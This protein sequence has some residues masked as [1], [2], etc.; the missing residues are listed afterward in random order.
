MG[1]LLYGIIVVHGVLIYPARIC[2]VDNKQ[3]D[4]PDGEADYKENGH[5]TFARDVKLPHLSPGTLYIP[6]P[7]E[8]D[9]GK[10]LVFVVRRTS[11]PN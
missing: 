4:D 3:P 11:K 2:S 6:S 10:Q 7:K 8:R 9:Q 1:H 5:I